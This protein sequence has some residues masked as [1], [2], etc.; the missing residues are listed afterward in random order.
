MAWLRK[1]FGKN[2]VNLI[3]III[4]LLSIGGVAKWLG[5]NLALVLP[6]LVGSLISFVIGVSLPSRTQLTRPNIIFDTSQ[7]SLYEK[8]A[9]WYKESK[10]Y[11]NQRGGRATFYHYSG[12][13]V[14]NAL[15]DLF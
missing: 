11:R 1:Y 12:E 4:T 6:V 8:L 3:G 5:T 14:H 10:F 9:S 2:H 15:E 7:V 13:S